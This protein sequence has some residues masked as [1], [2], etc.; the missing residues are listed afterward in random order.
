MKDGVEITQFN[1]PTGYG[2]YEI[3]SFQSGDRYGISLYF[4]KDKRESNSAANI[5]AVYV[6]DTDSE[7]NS[8][9]APSNE[10]SIENKDIVRGELSGKRKS[11]ILI[12]LSN[13]YTL[14]VSLRR[15]ENSYIV[16]KD[17]LP[18]IINGTIT[19]LIFRAHGIR[20][21]TN[22]NNQTEDIIITTCLP[23]NS[24]RKM[25][26][27]GEAYSKDLSPLK[28]QLNKVLKNQSSRITP[29]IT[30]Y[31]NHQNY[32][33]PTTSATTQTVQSTDIILHKMTQQ[34]IE[35]FFQCPPSL[36]HQY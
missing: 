5:Q 25:K 28:E 14:I 22:N 10:I 33:S 11:T 18:Y 1:T 4:E 21:I 16:R 17:G 31:I 19:N 6:C 32:T 24:W 26:H 36:T 3:K 12:R 30:E 13:S 23:P 7:H 29:K 20:I 35:Q 2:D 15:I 9:F 8:H 27:A 34:E